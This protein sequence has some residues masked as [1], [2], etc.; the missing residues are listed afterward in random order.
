MRR[1]TLQR[2]MSRARQMLNRRSAVV[3]LDPADPTPPTPPY[4]P[5]SVWHGRTDFEC[6]AHTAPFQVMRWLKTDAGMTAQF[7]AGT[8]DRSRAIVLASSLPFRAVVMQGASIVYDNHQ[9]I[10]VE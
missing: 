7:F 1:E 9:P 2:A 8:G 10:P 3:P 4:V 5:R 6:R